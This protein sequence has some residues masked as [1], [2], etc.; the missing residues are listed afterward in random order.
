M[1]VRFDSARKIALALPGAEEGTSYGTPAFRVRGK[2]FLR[3][4]DS[5]ESLV[6]RVDL[7]ERDLLMQADGKAYFITD[8]YKDHPMML[9]GLAHVGR[10]DLAGLIEQSW[11][12]VAPKKLITELEA[13]S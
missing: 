9:V 10:A 7:D 13:R 1:A 3:L 11:R 12:R 8:H 2:L 4:H 5:R 6:V